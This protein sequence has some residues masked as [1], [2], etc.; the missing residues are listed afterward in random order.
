MSKDE[1]KVDLSREILVTQDGY[2]KLVEEL[3][4]LKNVRRKE[5]AGH[6]KEAISYGDLSENSE[7]EE[8]KN[9]QAFVEGRVI[10]LENKIKNAKIVK[11]D[12]SAKGATVQ[13]GTV[14]VLLEQDKKGAKEE[15]Y[16]VVGSTE[17]DAFMSKVSNESPLGQALL[18]KKAGT[19]V[20]FQAPKGTMK[21]KI[22]KID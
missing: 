10:E 16:T 12:K 2:D 15:T 9:E 20:E 1:K 18:E 8:A 14:V 21:Y 3:A 13:L 5:V 17:A 7:Y 22:V 19:V 4:H 11:E 6:L